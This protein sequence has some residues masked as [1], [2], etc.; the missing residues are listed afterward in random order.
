MFKKIQTN[1]TTKSE[2]FE[3]DP[4]KSFAMSTQ[5]SSFDFDIVVNDILT[6][7]V[8]ILLHTMSQ[9]TVITTAP[10]KDARLDLFIRARC[11]D[12]HGMMF[13]TNHL[14]NQNVIFLQNGHDFLIL[15]AGTIATRRCRGKRIFLT[16]RGTTFQAGAIGKGQFI[17]RDEVLARFTVAQ[18]TVLLFV[19]G[20]REK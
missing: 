13:A 12:G 19:V 8:F 20:T 2:I 10:C 15:V 9:A 7:K 11:F 6:R 18:L 5:E 4:E 14:L 16:K 17:G 1:A 3:D